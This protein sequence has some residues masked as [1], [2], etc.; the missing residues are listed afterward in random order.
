MLPCIDHLDLLPAH[1]PLL[2]MSGILLLL[3]IGRSSICINRSIAVHRFMSSFPICQ[4][5]TSHTFSCCF[6]SIKLIL[7]YSFHLCRK[8]FNSSSGLSVHELP[9]FKLFSRFK[10][11]FH[12]E[13]FFS[14]PFR[15]I[16]SFGS[17]RAEILP[18][19]FPLL[20]SFPG[21]W[22]NFDHFLICFSCQIHSM[23]LT[24][25]FFL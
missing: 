17:F 19:F 18:S 1:K 14:F 4:P 2:W 5:S 20:S 10:D 9:F 15:I 12:P 24:Q 23:H 3:G 7:R 11:L 16:L 25:Y 21:V 8:R 6:S 22:D 13:F